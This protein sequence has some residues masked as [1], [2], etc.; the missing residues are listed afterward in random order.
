MEVWKDY[1][2]GKFYA[3]DSTT[4]RQSPSNRFGSEHKA[5]TPYST[6]FPHILP[7]KPIPIDQLYSVQPKKFD[8]YCQ[9][10]R[11][12]ERNSS[13]SP[14]VRRAIKTE[15]IYIKDESKI[16]QPLEFLNKTQSINTKNF[17]PRRTAQSL[18]ASLP[19][20]FMSSIYE[21]KQ[22]LQEKPLRSLRTAIDLTIKLE[23]EKINSKGYVRPT[24]KVNRRKLK[25]FF[26]KQFKT[27]GEL[28]QIE[29]KIRERTNPAL[30]EK[31][32]RMEQLDRKMLEKK[33]KATI[34]MQ[35]S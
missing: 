32:E 35:L 16:P 31:H 10:P 4:G 22:S 12:T 6:G 1:Q 24:S 13:K 26:L 25:G 18:T 3:I 8:G 7:S 27:S 5:F 30:L 2:T 29:R 17:S 14:Y 15:K 21:L 19:D 28:F 11:P 20:K 34:L 9:F 33:K 23:H